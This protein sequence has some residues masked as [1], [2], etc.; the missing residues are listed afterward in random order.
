MQ[1]SIDQATALCAVVDASGYSQAA[2]K[3]NKSHSALIYLVKNL[4]QQ[5]G[6]LIFNR[7]KYRNTLTAQGQKV[8]EKCHEI[9]LKVDELSSLCKQYNKGWEPS[10]KVVCD[11]LL[12]FT[13]FLDLYKKFQLEK[14]P[15][16]IQT[17]TDYLDNVEKSFDLLNADI[18][19]SIIPLNRSDLKMIPLK[20]IRI[21]L[22]AHKN[23]SIHKK[24]SK[25]STEE[26]K[27]FHYLSI[28]GGSK[29]IGLGT[30]EFE[31]KASF[32]L[33]DFSVKKEAILKQ[34]GFGWLP[35][36]LISSELQK[37][38]LLPIKWEKTSHQDITPLLYTKKSNTKNMSVDAS[39]ESLILN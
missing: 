30:E 3:L 12:P 39:I 6:F 32:F 14:I 18:M 8:Y 9:L 25:W 27:Q 4:E 16:I 1:I 29:K 34:S 2:V 7:E 22:V 10:L 36:H 5:C 37:K 23:H 11:G 38:T 19:I 15:T 26:L 17:Y 28:R 24:N 20:S 33:S 35:F 21:V 31:N 13:P